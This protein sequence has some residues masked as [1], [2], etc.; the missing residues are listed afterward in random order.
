M[1]QE[2]QT[3]LDYRAE[4]NLIEWVWHQENKVREH[5]QVEQAFGYECDVSCSV[6]FNVYP[7]PW[8]STLNKGVATLNSQSGGTEFVEKDGWI[9]IPLAWPYLAT[10]TTVW[11]SSS[12]TNTNYLKVS[13]QTVYQVTTTSPSNVISKEMV[14]NLGRYD[15][16]EFRWQMHYSWS[17]AAGGYTNW[18][19]KLKK[20]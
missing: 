17:G 7:W 11:W 14:L 18:T 5:T 6:W 12:M 20:L 15:T 8:D 13:W 9:R 10:I 19:L 1:A 2:V 3:T 4:L 16:V